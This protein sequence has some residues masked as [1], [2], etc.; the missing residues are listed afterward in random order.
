MD[1]C[2]LGVVQAVMLK[3]IKKT[4]FV[5]E[6]KKST[7]FANMNNKPLYIWRWHSILSYAVN[8]LVV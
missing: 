6:V 7:T 5:A 4:L 3:K 1:L 2:R 8:H